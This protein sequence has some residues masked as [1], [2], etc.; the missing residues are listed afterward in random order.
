MSSEEPRPDALDEARMSVGEHLDE[1]RTRL[2]RCLVA[3]FVIALLLIY[4]AKDL[5]SL[6]VRPVV[7]ALQANNQIDTLL[8]TSPTE[9]MMIYLKVVLVFA[10][11]L[12]APYTIYQVWQFV[13]AG[14]YDHEKH[15]VTRL[16]P[17]SV[18]LFFAGVTFMYTIV[19]LVSLN[20]LINFSSWIPLP[21]PELNYWE[22]TVVGAAPDVPR[23][24]NDPTLL[25]VPVLATDPV[26]P[27]PGDTW[28]NATQSKLKVRGQD[29]VWGVML[30]QLDHRPLATTH[31]K[32]GDYLNFVLSMTIAFGL[33]FQMPL[34]VLAI[35]KMQIF[36][37]QQLQKMRGYVYLTI[38]VAA[39]ILAPP[40]FLSHML[41][42]IPM[43][44]LYEGG[45]WMASKIDTPSA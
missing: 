22:Q 23:D 18:G 16:V 17:W 36:S 11:I 44:L 5:L 15:W 14:L 6:I 7:I 38:A 45:L 20:F 26:E 8:Q 32:I 3:F 27:K 41:L 33:A 10:L 39:G 28:F 25:N 29:H 24:P 13:A 19:L 35:V 31:F 42:W 12:S 1:L 30:Q 2:V 9:M 4:P 34:I 21:N 37:V 40:E 43:M